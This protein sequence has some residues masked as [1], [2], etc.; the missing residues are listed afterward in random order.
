MNSFRYLDINSLEHIHNMTLQEYEL[1][2]KA[3]ALKRLDSEYERH[4]QAFLN[5]AVQQTKERG[6]KVV[7]VYPTMK[8]FFDYE[9]VEQLVLGEKTS[10]KKDKQSKLKQ[11]VLIANMKGG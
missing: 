8:S 1:R 5:N 10:E 11:L 6:N 7:P 3:S 9:R 4:Q 2:M